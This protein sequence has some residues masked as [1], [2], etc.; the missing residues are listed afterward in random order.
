MDAAGVRRSNPTA[1]EDVKKE[2]IQLYIQM[3]SLKEIDWSKVRDLTFN[4]AWTVK[5]ASIDTIITAQCLECPNFLEHV[6]WPYFLDL[7]EV[8]EIS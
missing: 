4:E 8:R 6:Y 5:R 7:I 3:G 2:L 1:N